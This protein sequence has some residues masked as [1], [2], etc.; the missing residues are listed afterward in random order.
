ME[1]KIKRLKPNEAEI[2]QC[3]HFVSRKKRFCKMTVKLG[4][5]YCGEHMPSCA[6]NSPDLSDK[7][8]RVV[9]PLDRKQLSKQLE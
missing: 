3:K 6:T 9:C 2:P 1:N 4:E 8:L 5:E 7:T